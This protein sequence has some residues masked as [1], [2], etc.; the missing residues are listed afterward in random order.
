MRSARCIAVLWV[1]GG[2]AADQSLVGFNQCFEGKFAELVLET[3]WPIVTCVLPGF[4][5]LADQDQM[6]VRPLLWHSG[7]SLAPSAIEHLAD[8]GRSD[9]RAEPPYCTRWVSLW[10]CFAQRGLVEMLFKC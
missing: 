3:N 4:L 2:E 5:R 10:D 9:V 8:L 1:L 7:G 6:C